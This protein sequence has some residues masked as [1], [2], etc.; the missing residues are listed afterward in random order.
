MEDKWKILHIPESIHKIENREKNMWY[1]HTLPITENK[2]EI[3]CIFIWFSFNTDNFW[4]MNKYSATG[5]VLGNAAGRLNYLPQI[6]HA[7]H[8]DWKIG[9]FSYYSWQA[10]NTLENRVIFQKIF[11]MAWLC[12]WRCNY[13]LHTSSIQDNLWKIWI[14][15]ADFL[16]VEDTDIFCMSA[17]IF[18][19]GK[20]FLSSILK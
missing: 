17:N 16:P 14:F 13:F 2:M 5:K 7:S 1:C 4:K 12:L 6:F 11:Y 9:R 15:S 10:Q 20:H 3:T 18:D 19:R 8:Y